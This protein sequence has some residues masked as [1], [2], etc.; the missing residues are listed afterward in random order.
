MNELKIREK[1]ELLM[2]AFLTVT[3]NCAEVGGGDVM[4]M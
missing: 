3:T 4:M 1:I 2:E